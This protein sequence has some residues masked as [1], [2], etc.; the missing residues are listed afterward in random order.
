MNRTTASWLIFIVA[1][2]VF[3]SF[4]LQLSSLID[5]DSYFHLA[6][7]REYL[8]SGLTDQLSWA[9]FSILHDG[10]GDKEI[11]FHALIA[12]LTAGFDAESSTAGRVAIA[13][14]AALLAATLAYFGHRAVGVWGL[15]VPLLIMLGSRVYF[16]RTM[17][18]RPEVLGAVLL[19]LAAWLAGRQRYRALA[20]VAFVYT[21]SYTAFHALLGLCGLWFLHHLWR[22]GEAHWRLVLYP[23]LGTAIGL[24]VHPHFPHN[25]L[26]W[27]IQSVDFFLWKGVL[28]VGIEIAS[29]PASALLL[30]NIPWLIALFVFWLSRSTG[31]RRHELDGPAD[32]FLVAA[33]VFGVMTLLAGRFV[34]YALPFMTLALL[35]AVGRDGGL[36][37]W[38]RLPWRGRLP[39]SL[40]LG[41]AAVLALLFGTLGMWQ[42]LRMTPPDRETAARDLGAVLPEGAR[43]AAK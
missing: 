36:D 26:V 42:S 34:I 10:F 18:L 24:L 15:L 19:L 3:A 12:P 22:H 13:L 7:A 43:V 1:F 6:V 5:S 32:T 39:V 2:G 16:L 14:F 25:L 41:V 11:L 38:T 40:T 33:V 27:K 30:D 35:F 4:N 29:P 31:R 9:R 21:L 20:V 23:V 8:E 37:R 28:D 17:R